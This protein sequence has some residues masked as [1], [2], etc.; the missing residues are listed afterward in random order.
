[1]RR[2]LPASALLF[3]LLAPVALA[4]HENGAPPRDYCPAY[5]VE[6]GGDGS[7]AVQATSLDQRPWGALVIKVSELYIV[8]DTAIVNSMGERYFFSIWYYWESNG[9][10]G[11]QRQDAACDQCP[12]G[13]PWEC[14]TMIW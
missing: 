14:D 5:D 8:E 2:L 13:T 7:V 12:D 1:M 9:I 6:V 10:P 4:Y 3:A 11:L